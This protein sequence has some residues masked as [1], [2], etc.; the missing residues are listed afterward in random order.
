M[1]GE[2]E[3]RPPERGCHLMPSVKRLVGSLVR[4]KEN[5]YSLFAT[6]FAQLLANQRFDLVH[7]ILIA[8]QPNPSSLTITSALHISLILE[9]PN[10]G[11]REI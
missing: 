11:L 7:R 10:G 3:W 1:R 4:I 9:F 8:L 5:G 2:Q 6:L